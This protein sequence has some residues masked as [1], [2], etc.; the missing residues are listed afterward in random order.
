M[1]TKAAPGLARE[2]S[3]NAM[4]I[5]FPTLNKEEKGGKL[6]VTVQLIR[7]RWQRFLGGDPACERTFGLDAFGQEV[8]GA[9]DGNT[10]VT[11]IVTQFSKN[12]HINQAEA[13]LNVTTFL[14]TLIGK[15]LIGIPLEESAIGHPEAA[16]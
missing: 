10:T 15:G 11:E 14:K 16:S 4:P 6:Y 1:K 8:Y 3:M 5:A 2:Q 12:H 13:E 7:P 9:C